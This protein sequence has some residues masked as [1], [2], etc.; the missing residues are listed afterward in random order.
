MKKP[1]GFIG[2]G[3]MGS[4]LIKG[5]VNAG[6]Y[7]PHSILGYDKDPKKLDA[8]ASD[9]HITP[10]GSNEKVVETCSTLVLAVK[11]QDIKGVLKELAPVVSQDQ[12][13]ISIAAGIPISL[14]THLLGKEIPL[15]RAMPN[16]PA[17]IGKGV[18]ALAPGGAATEEHLRLA[19]AIFDAVGTTVVV[20]EAEMDAVTAV[21]GSGPGFVFRIM[22]GFVEAA[23]EGGLDRETAIALVT[24]TFLG[25]SALATESGDAL[26][27]LR[28]RVTSPGGTTAAGL[29]VMEEMGLDVILRKVIEAACTRSKEL[30]KE[31]STG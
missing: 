8:L 16:T 2:L 19:V 15:V 27:V 20:D 29:S 3:N 22:E 25:A 14:I 23:V 13:F 7:E 10:A 1:I 26:A 9:V 31:L 11:P 12:L 18:T 17:L 24:G 30:G 28:Q 5:I 4:A 21:S 6:L